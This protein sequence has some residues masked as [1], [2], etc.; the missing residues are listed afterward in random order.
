MTK[1]TNELQMEASEIDG[2]KGAVQDIPP[3]M[4]LQDDIMTKKM[5]WELKVSR[6]SIKL[7]GGPDN[8]QKVIFWQEKGFKGQLGKKIRGLIWRGWS[9]KMSQ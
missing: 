9:Q 7:M 6:L 5:F 4:Q 8:K 2:S 1:V 3:I